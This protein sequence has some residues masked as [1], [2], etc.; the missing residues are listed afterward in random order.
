MIFEISFS[1]FNSFFFSI[2]TFSIQSFLGNF[3][4]WLKTPKLQSCS[5]NSQSINLPYYLSHFI[6]KNPLFDVDLFSRT[7]D[8]ESPNYFISNLRNNFQNYSFYGYV[9]LYHF[10]KTTKII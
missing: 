10:L 8:M 4:F 9:T 6:K 7:F 5:K 2:F 3:D 1:I